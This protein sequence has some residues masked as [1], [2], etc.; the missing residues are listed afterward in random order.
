MSCV[1]SS[2]DRCGKEAVLTRYSPSVYLCQICFDG[3][4]YYANL[5]SI[6]KHP[7]EFQANCAAVEFIKSFEAQWRREFDASQPTYGKFRY[8]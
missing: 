7:T 8:E 5:P 6:P 2:C 1:Y 4:M 3:E